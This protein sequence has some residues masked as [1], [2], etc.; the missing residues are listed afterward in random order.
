M[1]P[2]STP[3][4]PILV[5]LLT[6]LALAAPRA[7]FAQP[8]GWLLPSGGETWTA[9]T[10]HTVEWTGGSPGWSV[11]VSVIRLVPFQN[12]DLVALGTTNDGFASWTIPANFPPGAYQLYVEEASVSTWTYSQ[13]FTVQAAPACA[14]ECQLVA[15]AM[16]VF[17][18]PVGACGQTQA[19]AAANAQAY[20]QQQL[21][22]ACPAGY[23]TDP[24]SVLTD[25]TFL[26]VGVCLSGYSG[27]FVAEASSVAC[28]CPAATPAGTTSWGRV[29]STYR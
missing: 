12:A 1:T 7:S 26:P 16:P 18:P 15:V 20:S 8:L 13:A 21:A 9:G 2:W 14:S 11:N 29:K 25:I 5:V 17:E 3:L 23:S 19:Q 6:T 22:G 28:C 10:T 24:S 4:R 27:A